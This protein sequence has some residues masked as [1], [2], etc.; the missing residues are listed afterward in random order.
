[1]KNGRW[2]VVMGLLAAAAAGPAAAQDPG[3]YVGGSFGYIQ[4]KDACKQLLVPCDDKD[5]GWRAFGGYQFSRYVAAELGFADLGAATGNGPLAGV[6]Q[7]SFQ[8]EVKEVF[9]LTAVFLFPVSSNL[10]GLARAGMYRART[11][12]DVQVT[13]FPDTH[14]AETNSGF[15]Y[16]A[17]AELRLGP[18]GVRA[19]WQRYENVGGASTGEDDLDV[20][21]IGVIVRF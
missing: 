9:D 7:G 8:L 12:L 5:T 14:D 11:T 6:G 13:G 18:L 3:L 17:G 10:S 20:F 19:E 21:S 1:M 2:L 15:S 16:G 4:Y